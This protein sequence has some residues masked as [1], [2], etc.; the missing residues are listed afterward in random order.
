MLRLGKFLDLIYASLKTIHHP[1]LTLRLT[2]TLSKLSQALFLYADHV[3]WMARSGVFS[4]NIRL[5]EWATFSNRY[6]LLS[7]TM[8]LCRDAYEWARIWDRSQLRA[9]DFNRSV[10]AAC[11]VRTG[12]D[13]MKITLRSY[14]ALHAHQAVVVDTVK[15]ACD[16]WIPLTALGYTRLTP[17]TIGVLG[18]VSS[19]AGLVALI[20][21]AAK[22]V[23]A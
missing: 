15:N 17:R 9:A 10:V 12:Q 19:V 14:A 18:V 2:L 6:W 4:K 22:L 23:P 7:I 3:V 5:A 11:S 13:L 21:P 16:V 20:K 1:D 8:N